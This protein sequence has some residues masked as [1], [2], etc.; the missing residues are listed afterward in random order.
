M[1]KKVA[2]AGYAHKSNASELCE[3]MVPAEMQDDFRKFL[4]MAEKL[5]PYDVIK[6]QKGNITLITSP[7]WDT[8]NEPIVGICRRWKAGMWFDEKE[9]S[10]N[11]KR[12]KNF[13]QIYHNKWQ[14]V[15]DDYKGFDIQA[16]KDRTAAWN[17]VLC[18]DKKRIGYKNYWLDFLK[19]NGLEE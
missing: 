6:Y 12:T 10:L 15:S 4:D 16:A 18:I 17:A 7:D 8:A 1:I 2:D 3:K 5:F 9:I 14:F 19:N 11:Y 13:K